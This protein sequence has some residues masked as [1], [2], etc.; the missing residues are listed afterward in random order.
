MGGTYIAVDLG[1][2]AGRVVAGTLDA[3]RADLREL[4]SFANRPVRT[5]DGLHWDVLALYAEAVAGLRNAGRAFDGHLAGIGVDGW[6]MDFGLID[7]AGRLLGNPYSY[8]DS[9]T[10]LLAPE[11]ARL[12]SPEELY[13]R[14]G[15]AAPPFSTI[16]QLMALGRSGDRSV[17]QAVAL[18]M[19]PDLLH[20]WLCGERAAEYTSAAATG[21][22]ALDGRWARDLLDRLA[23]PRHML[24]DPTPPGTMLG[25]L[26]PAVAQ[27][28]GLDATPVIAPATLD[29]ACAVVAM[30]SD[31]SAGPHAY[32][33]CGTR[34]LLGLEL[35]RPIVTEAARLAG[36]S[37]ERGV[38]GTYHFSTA[39]GGLWLVDECRRTWARHGSQWDHEDLLNQ[40]AAT[41]SPGVLIDVE[42]PAFLH[43]DSMP[44]AINDQ[45]RR[46]GQQE[47]EYA[48]ALVRAILEGLALKYRIALARAEELSGTSVEVVHIV[49]AGAR[50]HLLCQ[51]TADACG[52][53][54]LAGPVEGTALGNILVQA[55]GTG[56]IGGLAEAHA[57]ARAS[58]GIF[59]FEPF[60]P[61][62]WDAA[63][64]RLL[65]LRRA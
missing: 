52:R 32:I 58:G 59:H 9:R 13:G 54:V 35:D 15:V 17:D 39:I 8:R 28:C 14:T 42:D 46:T 10:D 40:A 21:A 33:C 43:P 64:A 11:A 12:V 6:G 20:F 50:N 29:T 4:H 44:E 65:A 60:D 45:L 55:I 31:P 47:I 24:L 22:L 61:G 38:A 27:E 23:A 63:Q 49:G 62:W 51:S 2:E 37:N 5:P 26:L 57:V 18:L 16:Y 48:P 25:C 30:P 36:F 3:G 56:E 7:A 1:S 19:I 41:G 53:P 34:S